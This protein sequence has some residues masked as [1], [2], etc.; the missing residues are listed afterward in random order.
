MRVLLPSSVFVLVTSIAAVGV[1]EIV[2]HSDSYSTVDELLDKILR[3]FWV[4]HC[5]IHLYQHNN[6]PAKKDRQLST[7]LEVEGISASEAR[8]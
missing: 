6:I 5:C 3:I 8:D 7:C 4:L 2:C 1:R